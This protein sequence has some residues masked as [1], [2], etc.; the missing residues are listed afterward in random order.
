M[1]V[2]KWT[3]KLT[4]LWIVALLVGTA[5][6]V[7]AQCPSWDA[8]PEGEKIA[9]EQH[10]LYRDL[11]KSKKYVEA[12]PIWEKLYSHVKLP[13]PAKTRHFRDGIT[14]YKEFAKAEEDKGTTV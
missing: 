9:K 10:V 1:L 2:R 11:F 7:A 6:T 14:M 12:F 4:Q 3:A 8:H 5:G 13:L